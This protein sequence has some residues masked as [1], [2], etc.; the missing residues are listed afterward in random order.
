[1]KDMVVGNFSDTDISNSKIQYI[2]MLDEFL[3]D[4]FQIISSY[5]SM[6]VLNYDDIDTRIKKIK[7]VT[8]E[9]IK[10]ISLKVHMDTVYLLKGDE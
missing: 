10:K 5:Y 8:F 6:N 4:P 3:E 9:D 7:T 2:T 1:M